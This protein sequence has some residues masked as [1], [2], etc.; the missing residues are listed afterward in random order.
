MTIAPQLEVWYHME[1]KRQ[2]AAINA[3]LK[4]PMPACAAYDAH[5]LHLNSVREF[6]GG[7]DGNRPAVHLTFNCEMCGGEH[8]LEIVN[9]KGHTV[10]A[11][12]GPGDDT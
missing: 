10:M 7:T 4:C 5:Y 2:G 1:G 9:Y 3:I 12:R 8:L 11:W 6:L